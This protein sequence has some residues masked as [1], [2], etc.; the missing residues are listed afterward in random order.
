VTSP[1]RLAA[2]TAT[3]LVAGAGIAAAAA[4]PVVLDDARP[5]AAA[6]ADNHIDYVVAVSVDGLNP[7]AIRKL[8]PSGAPYL[9]RL[10]AE[11]ASTLNARTSVESTS[12]LPNHTS[13]LTS[14]KI[15]VSQRGHGVLFNDDKGG[16]R[17]VH[18]AAGSY[19]ASVFDVVHDSGRRTKLYT[20]KD[21]FAVF[22]RSWDSRRGA[23]DRTGRNN[24]RDKISAFVYRSN[25]RTL[26]GLV[27]DDLRRRPAPFN[28]VHFSQTD[29]VGH[30]YGYMSRSYLNAVKAV[31]AHVG[32]IMRTISGDARLRAHA[33]LILTSDHGGYGKS[34][35]TIT[36]RVNYTIP[37]MVWGKGIAKNDLYAI[38][39][40]FRAPG[41]S[42]PGYSGGQPI[43]NGAV[44]NLATDLLDL[45]AI[46]RSQVNLPRTLTVFG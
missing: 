12:T 21:K 9:H 34:H 14:R 35:S 36:S 19:V 20:S 25:E 40:G 4:D 18:K 24:G 32:T 23:V 10:M 16:T 1:R 29:K 33:A 28:L 38:N 2:F 37:F 7:D 17:T 11:G 46:P 30:A 41:T 27:R 5:A 26:A 8:G 43:R 6:S 15:A 22:N 42:R 39:P 31:D 45:P 13:M 3:V 44:G